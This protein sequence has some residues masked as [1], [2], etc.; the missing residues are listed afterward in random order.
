MKRNQKAKEIEVKE[1]QL[2]PV[3]GQHD[4]D[5]KVKIANKFLLAGDKVKV[6]LRFKGRQLSHIEVGE[7]VMN[8][9]IEGCS[10]NC[11]IEKE[12]KLDGKLLTSILA[13]KYKK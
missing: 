12:A 2:S 10:E 1:I 8:R 6:A 3:I 9:F 11:I 5:T 13:S 4:L 7:E